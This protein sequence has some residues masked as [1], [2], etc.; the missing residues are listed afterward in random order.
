MFIESLL[1]IV[2][3]LER[4]VRTIGIS[5]VKVVK[6]RSWKWSSIIRAIVLWKWSSGL[7]RPSF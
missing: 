5:S 6:S 2:I 1:P 4:V 7:Y 3:N